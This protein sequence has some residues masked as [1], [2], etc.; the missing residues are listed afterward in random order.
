MSAESD[1][2]RKLKAEEHTLWQEITRSV[3]PLRTRRAV[4]APASEVTHSVPSA[5]P[6]AHAQRKAQQRLESMERRVK[7]RL[8]RG[9]EPIH[10]RLDLHGK[11]QAHAHRELLR[12]LR[13]AQMEGARFVLVITGKGSRTDNSERGILNRQVPLWLAQPNV[14]AYV[15][16][17]EPAHARHGGEGALYVRLRRAR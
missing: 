3:R 10:A 15:A 7:Q 14:R 17:F 16:S 12:F 9:S 4:P 11:T 2:P 6:V 13:G 1:R 5:A 8:A